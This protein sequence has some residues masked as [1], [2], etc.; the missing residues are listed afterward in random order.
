MTMT[1]DEMIEVIQAHRDG[2]KIEWRLKNEEDSP[3]SNS[4]FGISWD[5]HD[6]DYRIK[7]EPR[8]WWI[9]VRGTESCAVAFLNR[10]SAAACMLTA[11]VV[12]VREVLP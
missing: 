1:H 9:S 8:E 3:W 2:K 11:E 6:F 12:H 10:E 5:F 7:Q 4:P